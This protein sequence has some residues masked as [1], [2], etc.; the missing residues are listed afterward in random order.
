MTQERTDTRKDILKTAGRLLQTRGFNGFSYAHVAEEL[1]VKT[2]AVHY[3]FPS[4]TDLGMALIQHHRERCQRWMKDAQGRDAWAQLEGYL[5]IYEPFLKD[6]GRVCPG[7]ALQA[8]HQA[9]APEMQ[10]EL[11]AMV[12]EVHVWL[13]GV[14]ETG[15]RQ[16]AF[17]FDG[18][19]ADKA[20]CIMAA[21]QGAL[22]LARS[23]GK[24]A[25][26]A[27]VRQLRQDLRE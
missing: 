16:K 13:T 27:A 4:K 8:E 5:G 18:D 24:D 17:F 6:G 12:K 15:R 21:V 9:I 25:F 20:F 2:A 23:V 11:R 26:H 7:G 10:V 22:Q 3:H 19:A 1:G 14:L